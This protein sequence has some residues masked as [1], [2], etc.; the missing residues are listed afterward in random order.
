VYALSH[1][2]FADFVA[3]EHIDWTAASDNLVTSGSATMRTA[4]VGTGPSWPEADSTFTV[5]Q[6]TSGTNVVEVPLRV[7]H[8]TD[9]DMLD[10]FGSGVEFV[11]TDDTAVH[12]VLGA[13]G[14]RRSGADTEGEMV[15]YCGT[16]GGDLNAR[17]TPTGDLEIAGDLQ[18]DGN[19]IGD[20]GGASAIS[21]DG[22]QNTTLQ[23]NLTT[24]N[25]VNIGTTTEAGA[26]E[27]A[28]GA[29][30]V[31]FSPNALS[32]LIVT[33]TGANLNMELATSSNKNIGIRM[34]DENDW[35]GGIWYDH[36]T[37]ALWFYTAKTLALT[38]DS[39]QDATL[40]GDLDVDGGLNLGAEAGAAVGHI[41]CG[42][43]YGTT[44][45][46]KDDT[47]YFLD[48]DGAVTSMKVAGN[49]DMS[50]GIL[51]TDEIQAGSGPQGGGYVL[52]C[53]A[54]SDERAAYFAMNKSAGGSV[55]TIHQDHLTGGSAALHIDQDDVSEGF[56]TFS[57][58]NRGAV[59]TGSAAAVAI[60]SVASVRVQLGGSTKYVIPLFA[61][62]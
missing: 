25:A 48:P 15:F 5:E 26:G 16:N 36:N 18:V 3:N 27:L 56:I 28:V 47:D 20:S 35:A 39:N 8:D 10:G 53:D 61:D 30:L 41:R 22:A 62:Q 60:N 59:N 34:S 19:D 46:A 17:L 49:V 45:F 54:G 21:F 33:T 1:D 40:V 52:S 2:S 9:Q 11:V 42:A 51:Y 37:D 14:A 32:K 7:I 43:V 58:S 57:G 23:G 24:S 13:I 50:S 44:F 4:E 12:K 29:D 6:Q 38:L 31:G 55:V